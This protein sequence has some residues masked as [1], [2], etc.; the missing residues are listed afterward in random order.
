MVAASSTPYILDSSVTSASKAVLLDGE[1]ISYK[2][3]YG[4]S[5]V[6]QASTDVGY[7][8]DLTGQWS[9]IS[10]IVI[11]GNTTGSDG[12][13][14]HNIDQYIERSFVLRCSTY[15]ILLG[16]TN[17]WVQ[18]NWIEWN[19]IGIGTQD[20][21]YITNNH[22]VANGQDMSITSA[23]VRIE[24]N[25]FRN[26]TTR[27]LNIWGGTTSDL[28]IL[29]NKFEMSSGSITELITVSTGLSYAQIRNNIIE[30]DSKATYFLNIANDSTLVN[31][32][33]D[34]NDFRGVTSALNYGTGIT[35]IVECHNN[36]GYITEN[37]GTGSIA[38]A[39]TADVIT[40]GCSYTPAAA[41]I[42]ITLT[43]NPTTSPGAIWV[44]TIG[45]A[46]FTVNC[47]VDP[48]ASNLDFSWAVRKV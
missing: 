8:F 39:T 14:L 1:S 37:S 48:G 15:G 40:H 44:D 29:G 46:E 25:L 38:N 5:S 35:G 36:F 21:S 23:T 47:E 28:Q 42:V 43:E 20:R 31:V 17:H 24:S 16:G 11:D 19:T 30:G 9:S 41:D 27:S 3:D 45:A 7:M 26:P 4:V 22:F 32:A 13:H 10:H 33:M 2:T 18:N 6:F 34:N 12:V